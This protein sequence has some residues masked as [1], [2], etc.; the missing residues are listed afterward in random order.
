MYTVFTKVKAEKRNKDLKKVTLAFLLRFHF[1]ALL[2]VW[3]NN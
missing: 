1:L 3:L 2:V